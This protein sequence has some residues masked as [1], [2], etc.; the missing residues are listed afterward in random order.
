MVE[1]AF[2]AFLVVRRFGNADKC[3]RQI[4]FRRDELVPQSVPLS[5]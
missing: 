4:E 2:G 3:E 5:P 1:V